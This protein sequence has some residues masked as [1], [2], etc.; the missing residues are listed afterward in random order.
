MFQKIGKKKGFIIIAAVLVVALIIGAVALGAGNNEPVGPA[1]TIANVERRTIANSI[2]GNGV[3]EAA[4]QEDVTG[5]SM[6]MV[7]DEIKVEVG[8]VV[9]AG[10]VICVFDTSD[11]KERIADL[12]QQIADNEADRI[13]Q[14]QEYADQQIAEETDK[15]ARIVGIYNDMQAEKEKLESELA[16]LARLEGEKKALIDGG[17]SE[18]DASVMTVQ[19]SINTQ[20]TAV[21]TSQTRV[22]TYQARIDSINAESTQYIVDAKENYNERLDSTNESINDQIKELNEQMKE[23]TVRANTTGVVT[24]IY[25]SEGT[26]HTGGSIASIENMDDFI[27]EAQIEEYDIP[28][29]AAG[30]R[31][32]IKTDATR[33]EELEGIVTFVAPR[34]TNS[35]GSSAGGFSSLMGS[36]DTSSLTGGNGSATYLVKIALT[37]PNERLRLGMNAKV[38]IITEERTDTWSVPYDAVYTREDGSTYIEQVTG[39]D[40][41]GNI[42]TQEMNVNLGLQG[43]Y[44]VEVLSEEIKDG[45]QILIPDAQGNSSIQELLNMLGADAGI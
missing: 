11:Q 25:V 45:T 4:A 19:Q 9:A 42:L 2:S 39:K 12:K 31:V 37:Q 20:K 40:E 36:M 23:A 18:W 5:G 24:A 10:D 15:Y 8:D 33:T 14:N 1:G 35:G 6:G 44:Y 29:I 28:D 43:T 3:V 22:D 16:E 41:K 17:A 34:A 13:T 7:V 30:M 26:A 32:L 38:S 27:V 21:N